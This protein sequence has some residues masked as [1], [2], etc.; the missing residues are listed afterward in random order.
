MSIAVSALHGHRETSRT[1]RPASG[2]SHTSGPVQSMPTRLRRLE[3][4]IDFRPTRMLPV[5]STS[6]AYATRR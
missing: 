2:A 5:A 3:Y 6:R 1:S 4:F